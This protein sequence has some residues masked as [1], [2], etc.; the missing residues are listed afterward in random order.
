MAIYS[1][2]DDT[3]TTPYHHVFNAIVG[4]ELRDNFAIEAGYVGRRGR[5]LLIRRDM[6]M[7]IT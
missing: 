6:A 5:N 1:S 3:I 4:R 2:L 7:P